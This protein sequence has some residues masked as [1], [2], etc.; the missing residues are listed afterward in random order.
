MKTEPMYRH[1]VTCMVK[2]PF[3]AS[4]IVDRLKTANFPEQ[5]ISA[6]LTDPN[7][8]WPLLQQ[9]HS[10]TSEGVLAGAGTGAFIG[11][12]WGWI[13]GIGALT[14]PGVGLFLA[15]G[16]VICAMSG[17]ALG[18]AMGGV[19]GGLIG[20]GIPEMEAKRYEGKILKG[21]ILLSVH[22]GS[23]SETY[24]AKDILD[25]SRAED[26]WASDSRY[27]ENRDPSNI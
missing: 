1:S 9:K 19:C 3:Q 20:M 17:V 12:T 24:R 15:V 16:P 26:V 22:T 5:S 18:A 21:E 13:A 7:A 6:F 2:S 10:R 14:I 27:D 4:R 11:G 23:H 8:G 25:N